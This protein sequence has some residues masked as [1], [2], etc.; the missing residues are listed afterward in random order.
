MILTND[1]LRLALTAGCFMAYGLVCLAP[2]LRLRR[3]RRAGAAGQAAAALAPGWI[4]AYASQTGSA[5]ELAGQT[6]ETLRLAGIPARLCE[7]SELKQRDLAEAERIL[8]LV[9]T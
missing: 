4:V 5:E 3:K 9:S 2:W 1:P 7:L 8:F 6:L